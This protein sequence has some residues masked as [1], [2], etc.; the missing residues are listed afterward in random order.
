MDTKV[1]N[2]ILNSPFFA[3]K[4][5]RQE[6]NLPPP[7]KKI[8]LT[9]LNFSVRFMNVL[10]KT[11]IS[12]LEELINTNYE[13]IK[14]L[15]NCG[16]KSI[17]DAQKK[18]LDFLQEYFPE[19][20]VQQK[21]SQLRVSK[22]I[23]IRKKVLRSPFFAGEFYGYKINLPA[24]LK[25]ILL[26]QL[27]FSVRF[28]NILRIASICDLEELLNTSYEQIRKLRNCGAKSIEDARIKILD[29]IQEYSSKNR[30]ALYKDFQREK[31]YGKKRIVT[32]SS[33]LNNPKYIIENI[34]KQLNTINQRNQRIFELRF[35]K[36][37]SLEEIGA[38]FG[39]TRERVRQIIE[40][41]ISRISNFIAP[42]RRAH[43]EYFLKEILN[44]GKPIS[45]EQLEVSPLIKITYSQKM[46]YLGLLATLF[47]NVPFEGYLSLNIN[48]VVKKNKQQK[49]T[50][51]YKIYA[52]LLKMNVPFNTISWNVLFRL[53]KTSKIEE[54][55]FVLKMIFNMEQ[56]DVVSIN[57]NFTLIKKGPLQ[58]IALSILESSRIPLHVKEILRIGKKYYGVVG[59]YNSISSV[60]GNLKN[61]QNLYEVDKYVFGLKKHF[62]YSSQAWGEINKK[63]KQIIKS[64]GRQAYVAE[65]YEPLK[66]YFPKLRSK[67]ELVHILRRD[68]EIEDLGFF[69]FSL[70]TMGLT[71]RIKVKDAI[72]KLF[73][74]R[75]H[76]LHFSEVYKEIYQKRYIRIEGLNLILKKL[77]FLKYYGGGFYGLIK[78]EQV[79]INYLANNELYLS[80]IISLEF[81]PNTSF[82]RLLTIFGN[83]EIRP[84]VM[85]TI[86]SSDKLFLYEYP[87]VEPFVVLKDWA[88]VR[89]VKCILYNVKRQVYLEELKWM[90]SDIGILIDESSYYKI[91]NDNHIKIDNNKLSYLNI[92]VKEKDIEEILDICYELLRELKTPKLIDEICEY[93]NNEYIEI[94]KDEL[95]YLLKSD[96]R[97][98]IINKQMVIVVR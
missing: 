47:P 98:V 59:K 80:K 64:I 93:I 40:K 14:S 12:D 13:Q 28:M 7:L 48:K 45:C 51:F 88:I 36:S 84:F 20:E 81:Y 32:K 44:T 29:F 46:L 25:G 70:K 18:V 41:E 34:E 79:N 83:D 9:Q 87:E 75:G 43:Q 54:K 56:F 89:I 73:L 85:N 27:N 39:I 71:K 3:G 50:D 33:H 69:Y 86:T 94:S 62:S 77:R 78:E 90:L 53:L 38:E 31:D 57:G 23:E 72:L 55:L 22:P 52:T 30:N 35:G 16:I 96:D 11:S 17:Q 37:K 95:L 63:A 74:E 68:E 58:E 15:R 97:F 76:P 61:N 60:I 66:K 4:F 21:K 6:I 10:M 5:H 2:E 49:E 19:N 24:S 82:M 26:E 67:Y 8:A 65:I 91:K 42:N 92:N 1:K